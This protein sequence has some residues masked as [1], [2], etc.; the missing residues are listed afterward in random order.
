MLT[1]KREMVP[2]DQHGL[3]ERDGGEIARNVDGEEE[4]AR[5]TASQNANKVGRREALRWCWRIRTPEAWLVIHH[6][7]CR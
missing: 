6:L 3:K 5:P 4:D 2:Q 1:G 7:F